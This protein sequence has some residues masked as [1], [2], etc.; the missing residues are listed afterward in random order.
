MK[1]VYV[2]VQTRH[3]R[4]SSL[5]CQ[6]SLRPPGRVRQKLHT[7]SNFRSFE[8]KHYKDLLD[9]SE[10]FVAEATTVFCSLPASRYCFFRRE[11]SNRA[12]FLVL[13]S[14]L[15][16]RVACRYLICNINIVLKI[17][18]RVIKMSLETTDS[19]RARG[20]CRSENKRNHKVNITITVEIESRIFYFDQ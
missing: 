17:Q 8:P 6:P 14:L 11:I 1:K 16:I 18:L 15:R 10:K 5:K 2:G 13:F 12:D 9:G 19:P 3:L 20:V 4:S 7:R